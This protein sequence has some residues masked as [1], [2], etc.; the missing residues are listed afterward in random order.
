MLTL[1]KREVHNIFWRVYIKTKRM[2]TK[3]KKLWQKVKREEQEYHGR[4][5]KKIL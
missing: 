3:R 4:M 2:K 1:L 5:K